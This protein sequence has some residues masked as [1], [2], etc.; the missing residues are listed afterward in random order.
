MQY[1]KTLYLQIPSVSSHKGQ[2]FQPRY[3][4]LKIKAALAPPK[5]K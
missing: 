4:R 1:H 5:A 3:A 2:V